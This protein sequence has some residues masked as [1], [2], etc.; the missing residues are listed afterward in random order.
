MQPF[1]TFKYRLFLADKGEKRVIE[2]KRQAGKSVKFTGKVNLKKVPKIYILRN[3]TE[4]V[5]VGFTSQNIGARLSGGMWADGRAGYHG[6]KWRNEKELDLYVIVFEDNLTDGKKD[7]KK[8]IYETIEAEL[9]FTIRQ[10]T[11]R[12]PAF[13]NEIHFH[14]KYLD[15]VQETVEEI[16]NLI[17]KA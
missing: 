9:V 1:E 3:E 12:Y 10:S 7:P 15:D 5:Y 2:E 17:N 14:N 8:E 6:Y 4:I 13:Q 11:G 16:Y